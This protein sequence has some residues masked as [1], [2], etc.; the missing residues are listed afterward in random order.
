[1]NRPRTLALAALGALTLA[2]AAAANHIPGQP[3]PNCTSHKY[4]PTINGKLFRADG[5]ATERGTDRSDQLMGHHGSDDLRTGDGSDILWG[6]YDPNN[7]PTTQK[8]VMWGGNGTDFIY[9][10][11]GHNE[12]YAGNGNDVISVHYGRGVVNCGPGRDIYHVARSRKSKYKFKNCEKVDY[13]PEGV[14]GGPLKPLS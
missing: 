8:D 14:R 10:S 12:I 9:G 13:R 4:W 3:C 7:Q 1:M 5:Q 2:S 6:D 11:H